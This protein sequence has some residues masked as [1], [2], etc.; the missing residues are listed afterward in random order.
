M[1]AHWPSKHKSFLD[2]WIACVFWSWTRKP[3]RLV[4]ILYKFNPTLHVTLFK[5]LFQFALHPPFLFEGRTCVSAC[6]IFWFEFQPKYTH[7]TVRMPMNDGNSETWH[8]KGWLNIGVPER[9]HDIDFKFSKRVSTVERISI[10][11][12]LTYAQLTNFM[13]CSAVK[14]RINKEYSGMTFVSL[15]EHL[16]NF[17]D[18]AAKVWRE[19]WPKLSLQNRSKL[20]Q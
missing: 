16:H 7:C 2:T 4:S 18:D 20:I 10:P 8:L 13:S 9:V 17:L 5:R 6:Y 1:H 19:T 14:R 15:L 11:L 3:A 12:T